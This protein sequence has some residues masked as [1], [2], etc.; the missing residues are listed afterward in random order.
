[1]KSMTIKL[2]LEM[3]ERDELVLPAMQRPFV[4]QE[5]RILRLMD[6]LMR[7]FPIGT[8]LI[9]ETDEAQ[10]Y[11][12]FARAAVLKEQPLRNFPKPTQANVSSTCLT[13]SSV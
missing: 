3:I 8:V 11:R 9:W 10:R 6:S 4:W 5:D 12:T 1:M 7:L 2:L 13:D